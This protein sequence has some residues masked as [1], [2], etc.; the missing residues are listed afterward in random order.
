MRKSLCCLLVSVMIIFTSCGFININKL[1][2]NKQEITL[3]EVENALGASFVM[4]KN[5][6]VAELDG[7]SYAFEP[8]I[9]LAD[10]KACI[11]ATDEVLDRI[12][13]DANISINIFSKKTYD[14]N[15]VNA[16][17]I[18]TY[19]QDW[20]SPEYISA[21][22]L[23]IFGEYCNYGLIYGYAN[24]L[25]HNV[26]DTPIDTYSNV[27]NYNGDLNA[28][29]LNIICFRSEFFSESEIESI[30]RISNTFVTEFIQDKG[31]DSFHKL[32]Q[33]SGDVRNVAIFVD[34]LSQFYESKG[35]NYIP[36][37]ILYRLGGRSYDYIA[38]CE[39][40][41]MYIEK[42]WYDGNKELCPYTYEGFLHHNYEDTRKFFSINIEQM[43]Q[44]QALFSLDTYNNDLNI[45]FTNHYDNMSVYEVSK[46]A[47]ALM[48]TGSLM[49]EYVHALTVNCIIPEKWA[50]E[51]FARYFGYR[52]DYYGNA[53]N[54]VDYN[55]VPETNRF[56][57]IHEYKRS[58]GRDIDI[59]K[60]FEEL[61]H[62]TAYVY[63]YDDPNDA[64]GYASGASFIGYL[65]SRF[66]E[67][68]VIEI[69]CETHDFGETTFDE[70]VSDWL[71]FINENYSE[72]TKCK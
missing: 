8:D 30:K 24:Y 28:L 4:R 25:C 51:G 32:L 65:I 3:I 43:K 46:H 17:S 16:S 1:D 64:G 6:E 39:Y 15:F 57:Y 69:I 62:I 21:L 10:R 11:K 7:T 71:L 9:S 54:N 56:L 13:I 58:V 45:F 66:G 29:D 53:M 70:L 55:S 14:C 44:Y 22:L 23:G 35:I 68:E 2:F 60:D 40:A 61:Q 20:K 12:S 67:K 41:T 63:G 48:N 38:S 42:D 31:T 50:G 33:N 49:H 34:T 26:F 72:Y 27:G 19:L 47:I 37:N 52:Y 36:S 59:A 18:F 5:M